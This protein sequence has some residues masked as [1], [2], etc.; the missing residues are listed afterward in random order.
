M[1]LIY[2]ATTVISALLAAKNKT[3]PSALGDFQFPTAEEG[4]AIPVVFGTVKLTGGNTVWWGDL[5]SEGMKAGSFLGIGGTVVGYKYYIGV[6][7]ALCQ[8]I[9]DLLALQCDAK[10]VP[11][12]SS[13][14][15]PQTLTVDQ[16]SLFGGDKSGGGLAGTITFYRG[17]KTQPSDAYLSA[18]QTA[19]PSTPTYSG[20]GNGFL[21]FLAPGTGSVNE[22]ITIK[23]TTLSSGHMQFS[24]TGSVSGS[25][26]TAVADT[27]FASSKI[28]FLI[29][30]GSIQFV[31]ND[32]FQVVTT[33]ARV[34]PNY[35]NLCY[36][37]L[38]QF[39]VGTSAYP[40]PINFVVRRCPDPFGQ[41]NS[42]AR[43]NTD[44]AGGADANPVL[45]IHDLLTNVDYGLGVQLGNIDANNF[46]AAAVT[47]A[48]EGLGI[49]TQV[50]T[51]SSADSIIAEILRHIDGFLYVEPLTGLWT[52]TLAR[53]DYDPSTVPVLTVD[54]VLGLPKFS[55]AQWGETINQ[56]FVQYIDRGADYQMRTVQNHDLANVVLTGETRPETMDF[57]MLS[58][59]ADAALIATRALRAVTYPLSKLTLAANRVAWKWRVG[60][61][62]KFTW[63]PLGI[64][65]LIYRITRIA[66]GELLDGKISI[67]CVEDVFGISA[68]AFAPPPASGWVNPSG[69]PLAPIFQRLVE[70]PYSLALVGQTAGI[71]VYALCARQDGTP[72]DFQVWQNVSGTYS[73]TND[74]AAFCPVGILTAAYNAAT[75]ARDATGFTVGPTGADLTLPAST[76]NAGLF[77]GANLALIDDEIISWKT[78]TVNGDGSITFS[79]VLRGVLDTVPADH[80][81]GALV[82]FFSL[83]EGLTQTN[84][85]PADQTVQAKLL[86]VNNKGTY[87]LASAAAVSVATRSRYLRPF[88]PGNLRI[89]GNG[90]GVRPPSVTGDLTFTWSSRNRL[91]QTANQTLVLQDAGDIAGESG[92]TFSVEIWLG[93]ALKRRVD[94]IAVET[95]TYTHAQYLL[96]DPTATLAPT[97]KVFS[98]TGAAAPAGLDS[99]EPQLFTTAML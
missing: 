81:Q 30:T 59:S 8:G 3:R 28:N 11:Y 17:T 87:P 78:K 37:V 63:T 10:P 46:K 70:V 18:K 26:G 69:P 33:P 96:D 80:A 94:A 68:A 6:Q 35:K 13:G 44:G 19:V 67:E 4:R 22:T 14:S 71:L 65:A 9:V 23:A 77:A 85:Y 54:N 72:T 16:K 15:D 73:E 48:N 47:L 29:T 93:G 31:T 82:W 25:I 52:I 91:T 27:N 95:Y 57:K 88:A 41:G 36:A 42:V 55:R 89:Q 2:V 53:A 50:D 62:F 34:S 83:A 5:R 79:D 40:K 20:T 90:Y 86:P 74:L 60:G 56:I 51:P 84:V 58:N 7:Y 99:F 66:W 38:N 76:D 97:L 61:V 43:L 92:Q 75:P 39:Y 12:T 1:L 32:Q 49:S 98:H 21:A 24:V 64:N 45:A